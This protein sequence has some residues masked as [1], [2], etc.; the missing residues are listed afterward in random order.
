MQLMTFIDPMAQ[1][2]K[3]NRCPPACYE[4]FY[5]SEKPVILLPWPYQGSLKRIHLTQ[6]QLIKTAKLAE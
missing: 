2:N 5:V 4:S 3:K 1:K 6:L